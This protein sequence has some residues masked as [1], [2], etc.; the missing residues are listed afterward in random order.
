MSLETTLMALIPVTYLAFFGLERLFPARALP[1]VRGWVLKGFVFFLLSG[2]INTFVPAFVAGLVTKGVTP[3]DLRALGVIPGALVVLVASETVAYWVHRSLHRVHFVWRWSHQMH[4]SA[5]RIDVAG[6]M[7]F[8]PL[9]I[10]MQAG[11]PT[12]LV[13]LLGVTDQ[14]AALAGFTLFAVAVFQH[15]NVKTPRWLGYVVLRPEQHSVHHARGVHAYNYGNF[16]FMDLLF[17]TFRNPKDFSPEQGF[18]DGASSR[19]GAMLLG[20]DV[21]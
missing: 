1:K 3:V 10:A 11:I 14:A 20:R 4:H 18:W 9:D 7:Y 12:I 17:G 2:V 21:A 15:S 8:H 16:A 13:S 19:L 6:S 5:E